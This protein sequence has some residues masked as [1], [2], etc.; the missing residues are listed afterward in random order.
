[1]PKL[2]IKLSE[3]VSKVTE[4]GIFRDLLILPEN[5]GSRDFEMGILM[6]Q[7]GQEWGYP[8]HCH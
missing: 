3:G 7:P 6:L 8:D 4:S 5:V 1:M 2:V